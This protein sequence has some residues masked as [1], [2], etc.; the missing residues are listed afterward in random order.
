M[1]STWHCCTVY[2]LRKISS[3]PCQG[4]WVMALKSTNVYIPLGHFSGRFT[5]RLVYG[6]PL[7]GWFWLSSPSNLSS[8][9][10]KLATCVIPFIVIKIHVYWNVEILESILPWWPTFSIQLSSKHTDLCTSKVFSTLIWWLS[11][12]NFKVGLLWVTYTTG[13]NEWTLSAMK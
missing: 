11:M 6:L 4:T 13:I 3:I 1:H 7:C 5:V 9:C 8:K 2:V 12:G 10:S